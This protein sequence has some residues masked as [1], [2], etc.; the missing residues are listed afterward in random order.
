MRI[1]L[2]AIG[3][4]KQ[5]IGGEAVL[6]GMLPGPYT[7][8]LYLCNPARLFIE[9][10]KDPQTVQ[11]ALLRL[12]SCLADIGRA[13]RNAGADFITVHEMGGSPGF[14][15]P[16]RYEQFVHPAVGRLLADLAGPRVLS[17]CGD[18]TRSLSLLAESD[19]EAI[20]LDQT[21]DLAAARLALGEKLLFGN[22]DPVATLWRGS[23]DR[24]R[25]SARR[26]REAGVDAV[27][28]G[29]DLVPHTPLA[30]LRPLS[31]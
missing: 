20:S 14:L 26:A 4:T 22:L 28:P 7:L 2:E 21:V 10:K 15:G 25:E 18:A 16:A 30:H 9:M 3:M 19:A 12:A 11:D 5:E 8:L 1:I 24:T 6:S 31:E 27:W 13:Y 17:V 23:A 29:C